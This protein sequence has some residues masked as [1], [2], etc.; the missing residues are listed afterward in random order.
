M[1]MT[2][3][4]RTFN[5]TW[6]E[7]YVYLYSWVD[8]LLVYA[9]SIIARSYTETLVTWIYIRVRKPYDLRKRLIIYYN[10]SFPREHSTIEGI[11][12]YVY[13]INTYWQCSINVNMWILVVY[14]I[15]RSN[16]ESPSLHD[17]MMNPRVYTI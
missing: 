14:R 1:L 8:E 5:L 3:A 12:I 9:Y 4:K 10:S 13:I 6:H 16:D 15:R 17:L 2:M 11:N 7:Q